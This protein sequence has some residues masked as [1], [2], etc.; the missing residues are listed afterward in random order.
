M[1]HLRAGMEKNVNE[2]D[3]L[4]L[5]SQLKHQLLLAIINLSFRYN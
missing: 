5:D 2:T 4:V 1:R 3:T